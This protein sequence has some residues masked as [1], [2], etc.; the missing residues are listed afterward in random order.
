MK[1]SFGDFEF[2]DARMTLS[3][4]GRRLQLTR[5]AVDLLRLLLER[6]GEVVERA[7]IQQRLW[8]DRTV[9]FDHSVDVLINRLRSVLG[10]TRDNPQFIET[11]PKRGYRFIVPLRTSAANSK[12]RLRTLMM[13]TAVA[14]LSAIAMMMLARTRYERL[15]PNQRPPAAAR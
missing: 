13:Y 14:I 5:Q 1:E 8:P 12:R 3:K 2:D 6:H 10:D 11:V 7:E 4:G 9:E 15:V